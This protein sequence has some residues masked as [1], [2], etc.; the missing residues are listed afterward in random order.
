MILANPPG[1]FLDFATGDGDRSLF[2]VPF[3]ARLAGAIWCAENGEQRLSAEVV[4]G[5]CA[6]ELIHVASRTTEP[7]QD[8]VA[9]RKYLSVVVYRHSDPSPVGIAA[10][11]LIRQAR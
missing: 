11:Q 7:L 3:L 10:P 8:Q 5:P 1:L 6:G 2:G 9:S 4:N